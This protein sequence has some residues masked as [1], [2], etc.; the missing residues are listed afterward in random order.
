MTHALI[1]GPI[2]G[3]IPHGDGF[4]DVTPDVVYLHSEEEAVALADS[5]EVEH[6]VRGTHPL[7]AEC[8]QLDDP[9]AHPDGIPDEVRKAHQKAHKALRKKAGL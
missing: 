1:T 4:A 2:T 7:D 5:I 9:A 6:A 8:A 3:R